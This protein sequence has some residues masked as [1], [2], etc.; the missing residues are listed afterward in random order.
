MIAQL[1]V[2]QI[3][4]DLFSRNVSP[5][6]HFR[7]RARQIDNCVAAVVLGE[8]ED[9][10]VRA[11]GGGRCVGGRVGREMGSAQGEGWFALL[12]EVGFESGFDV[13]VGLGE[14]VF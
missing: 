2:Y 3:H 7:E 13:G 9:G 4:V 6:R 5:L 14:V 11:L 1:G 8:Q 12:A 10:E